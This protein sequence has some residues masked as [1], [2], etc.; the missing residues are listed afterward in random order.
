[1]RSSNFNPIENLW[2]SLGRRSCASA[3]HFNASSKHF[4]LLQG[5]IN[6]MV[7]KL[8]KTDRSRCYKLFMRME[9]NMCYGFGETEIGETENENV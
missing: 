2:G 3:K 9:K 6:C 8:D 5:L 1:M 7:R 4:K